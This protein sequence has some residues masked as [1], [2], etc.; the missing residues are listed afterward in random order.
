MNRHLIQAAEGALG[1]AAGTFLMQKGMGLVGKLPER[2]QPHPMKG[3]P[4]EYVVARAERLAGRTLSPDQRESAKQKT[5]WVYGIGWGLLLGL[6]APKIDLRSPGR[7]LAA[8]AALGAGV[9]TV[10]YAGWLP[11]A[12]LV[13]PIH[14]QSP[15]R[16]L[17]PLASHVLFGVVAALPI[18]AIERL[19]E[20]RRS[21]W[22]RLLARCF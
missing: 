14:R 8:G 17:A 12:G 11:A 7:A 15:K 20:P 10:G 13:D 9:W 6:L 19:R 4:A 5:H 1:A 3:D 2:F 18:L 22:Q 16:S 21:R